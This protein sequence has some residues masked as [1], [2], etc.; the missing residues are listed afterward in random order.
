MATTND[1]DKY[2]R[3]LIREENNNQDLQA[4]PDPHAEV[5]GD[6]TIQPNQ[7]RDPG[8]GLDSSAYQEPGDGYVRPPR[9]RR[10]G[11]RPPADDVWMDMSWATMTPE[12]MRSNPVWS[13]AVTGGTAQ[14]R[15]GTTEYPFRF[16]SL[17]QREGEAD[18]F[19]GQ[20][21]HPAIRRQEGRQRGAGIILILAV[22]GLIA[23]AVI[24]GH[25]KTKSAAE[26]YIEEYMDE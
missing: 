24:F 1:W 13:P 14:E 11:Y 5:T 3:V 15:Y 7:T 19:S 9:H 2:V 8:T 4:S 22:L 18:E 16:D 21:G 10:N 26:T 23:A 6:A 20:L 25:M 12:R 17:S